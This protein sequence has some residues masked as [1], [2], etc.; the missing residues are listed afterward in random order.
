MTELELVSVSKR[1]GSTMALVDYSLTVPAGLVT[2]FV[3]AN[4]A[5][6]S[7]AMRLLGGLREPDSG[8]VLFDGSPI[9]SADRAYIG[10]MPEERGLYPDEPLRTQLRFFATLVGLSSRRAASHVETLLETVGIAE[11][12]DR[13]FSALSLGNRQR[14][15]LALA[16]LDNPRFL[17]LDEPFS[18]LDVEGLSHISEFVRSLANDGVGVLISSHQLEVVASISDRVAVIAEGHAVAE[19]ELSTVLG[20]ATRALRFTFRADEGASV[21]DSELDLSRFATERNGKHRRT[22]GTAVLEIP[23][24][25]GSNI[26]PDLLVSAA[27]LG[28]LVSI[29][30]T[31]PSLRELVAVSA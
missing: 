24:A 16:L 19:G 12:A 7:T 22:T 26:D 18:G 11:L 1:F 30:L 31:Q 27:S 4:G 2:A 29:N 20:T 23:V 25:A 13:R 15:Q 6:K 9:T 10:H 17:L 28:P 8:R 21:A 3:G 14:A 5:G